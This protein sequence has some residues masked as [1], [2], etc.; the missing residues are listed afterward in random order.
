VGRHSPFFGTDM[1]KEQL[2]SLKVILQVLDCCYL[3]EKITITESIQI[4]TK[5]QLFAKTI[6]ELED[7]LVKP[8]AAIT[9]EE[10][11]IPEENSKL[12]GKKK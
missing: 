6:K 4:T 9:M 8:I 1:K 2:E 3:K 7:E 12:K 11:A 10:L 5:I